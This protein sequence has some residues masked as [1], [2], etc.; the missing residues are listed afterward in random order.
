MISSKFLTI[1]LTV[2]FIVVIMLGNFIFLL[3]TH[4]FYSSEF[5]KINTNETIA[6]NV[7]N[8]VNGNSDLSSNFNLRE[9]SHLRDV[10]NLF[11]TIYL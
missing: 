7:V 9:T 4:S 5:K 2:I 11:A 10:K 6:L 8:F 3:N 1:L